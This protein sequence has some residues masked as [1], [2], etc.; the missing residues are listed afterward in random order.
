MLL[1]F[2]SSICSIYV[3]YFHSSKWCMM[4]VGMCERERESA[5]SLRFFFF[6]KK[7]SVH[8]QSITLYFLNDH[9]YKFQYAFGLFLY[10]VSNVQEFNISH[11]PTTSCHCSFI[12]N[13]MDNLSE[14]KLAYYLHHL[15]LFRFTLFV[16]P[17]SKRII[18]LCLYNFYAF[19]FSS[20]SFSMRLLGMCSHNFNL[21]KM[22]LLTFG[23]HHQFAE[24]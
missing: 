1:L 17:S 4:C 9:W 16:S 21:S 12:F 22:S 7:V 13:L 20:I 5:C 6:S 18:Y 24:E 14:I 10:N 3:F 23:I 19:I 11:F 8:S 15:Y 2:T